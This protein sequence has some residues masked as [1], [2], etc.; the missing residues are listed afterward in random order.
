MPDITISGRQVIGNV[1]KIGKQEFTPPKIRKNM[2]LPQK[3]GVYFNLFKSF[4]GLSVLLTAIPSHQGTMYTR[5]VTSKE[6]SLLI[7]QFLFF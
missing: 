2:N 1:K 6:I 3:I 4:D 5:D 7:Y